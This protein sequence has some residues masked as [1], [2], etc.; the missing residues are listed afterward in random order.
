MGP[1][2][3]VLSAHLMF[4]DVGSCESERE[5][6]SPPKSHFHGPQTEGGFQ[7][8]AK[9]QVL[10][11]LSFHHKQPSPR[12]KDQLT[13]GQGPWEERSQSGTSGEVKESYQIEEMSWGKGSGP[14]P[15]RVL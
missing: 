13:I 14:L 9:R 1:P 8:S 4:T 3:H 7:G 15:V 2:Y 6:S 5:T 12:V 11:L 10:H